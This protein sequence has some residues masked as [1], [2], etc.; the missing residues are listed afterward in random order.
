[1]SPEKPRYSSL[2][3]YLRVV[4]RR[5][6][7][8]AL[9]TLAVFAAALG[10]SLAQDEIYVAEAQI[11]FRDP[12]AD[13]DLVG[14]GGETVPELAPN[15]RAAANAE[16][17]TRPEVTRRVRDRLDTSLSL[18]ALQGAI[19][20]RVSPQ[21]NL[22]ILEASW[23]DAEFVAE[24]AN[25]YAVAA[26]E[27]AQKDNERRLKRFKESLSERLQATKEN[28]PA[29]GEPPADPG[30]AFTIAAL[31]QNLANVR[32]L[33]DVAEPV[34]IAQRATVPGSPAAP[35]PVRNGILGLSIGLV[36]GL[37]VAFVRDSL[38]RRL[39]S[40]Q[41]VHDELEVPVL[42]RVG[43]AAFSYAGLVKNGRPV[44]LENDFEPFRVLRM[45]LAFL[46]SDDR[47]PRSVLITSPLAM[48]GKSTVSVSLASAAALAG[49]Q[50]LLLEC[51]LRRPS[52]AARLN[53]SR[54]PGLTDFLSGAVQPQE[55]LQEVQISEP[56]RLNGTAQG[57]SAEN[58]SRNAPTASM[59]CITAGKAVPNAPELLHSDRFRDM[60][61]KLTRAYDLV[62]LDGS[63]LL[64][65]SDPLEV[66]PFVDGILV[67]VRSQQTTREQIRSAKSALGHLPERPMG[68]VLTGLEPGDESYGYY[69]GY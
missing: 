33:E 27:V 46:T 2:G 45:N 3:D 48:E 54:A 15:Q 8:I 57:G 11:Q 1:M 50:V 51:D 39:H 36:L 31:S 59:V 20:A 56:R 43:A 12:L 29:P 34:Q 61:E 62:I 41:E 53:V 63:P 10:R 40:A 9:V 14:I 22:V 26:R 42:G 28:L 18:A 17:V 47:P 69:Y 24:L 25:G 60:L 32:S 66:A 23:G 6:L 68:A 44:M 38:D 35:N 52:L 5:R 13:L 37:L 55:I 21:T 7:L 58:K 65:V 4:R 64:A 67:C 49:Q 16:L 30:L 19:D